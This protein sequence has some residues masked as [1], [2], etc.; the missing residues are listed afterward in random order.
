[1]QIDDNLK[2]SEEGAVYCA[3]CLTVLG[4]SVADPLRHALLRERPSSSAGPGIHADPACFTDRPIVLRQ[5]YC[6]GCLVL[7]GT[8]IVPADEASFR[9]WTLAV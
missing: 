3:H 4:E 2:T 8:E 1:M 6:P 9:H 5:I 7:L